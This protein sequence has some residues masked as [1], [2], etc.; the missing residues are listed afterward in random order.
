M[1][2]TRDLYRKHKSLL[3]TDKNIPDLVFPPPRPEW[4]STSLHKSYFRCP[5]ELDVLMGGDG[6]KSD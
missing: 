2:Y 3:P 4:D 5:L 1:Q 6:S